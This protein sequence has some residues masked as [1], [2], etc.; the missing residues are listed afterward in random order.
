MKNW[1]E[2]PISA[3]LRTRIFLNECPKLGLKV[4]DLEKFADN[5]RAFLLCESWDSMRQEGFQVK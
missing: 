5:L 3:D 2:I 4:I 1:P